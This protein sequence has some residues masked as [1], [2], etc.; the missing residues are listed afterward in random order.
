[1]QGSANLNLMIKAARK[2]GRSL[3]KDF[4]EV[5]NLQ[6][7]TKGPGDFVSQGRPRGRADHQGRTD[8][9]AADLWLAGR[10]N[11]RGRTGQDPTRRWIVDPLDGTTNFLHGLPHWAV[12][13]ALEHKGEIVSAW[14]TTR[15]R[16]RCSGRKGRGRLAE[17]QPP[18]RVSG[19]RAMIE[20]IFATGVPFG[21]R[22]PARHLQDLARLMPVCAGVR[23][24]GAAALDLAY[25]AAGRFDGYW[26]R[27]L[28]PGTFF[29][30]K[31]GACVGVVGGLD[32]SLALYGAVEAVHLGAELYLLAGLRPDRQ[33][34]E[35][36]LRAVRV[37]WATPAQLRLLA[38][39]GGPALPALA[40]VVTGG[41]ALDAP[42][43]VA[44]AVMA[45]GARITPFYG[46]AEASFIAWGAGA[47]YPG[48]TLRLLDPAGNP[49]SEGRVALQSPYLFEDYAGP[50]R[51]GAQWQ[52]GWL[53]LDEFARWQ[54]D[55]LDLLG[56]AGRMVTIADRNVWP[57]EIELFL[58]S[59][60][61]I[62][63]AAVLP[64]PD[65]RRGHLLV[66]VAQGDMAAGEAALR[67][68]RRRFGP[69]AAPRRI[70]WRADWPE[71]PSGKTDL[72]AL[73]AD[74]P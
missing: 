55:A 19:R 17:R 45:P 53:V 35:L 33:R 28:K 68:L 29:D 31:P 67:A 8:G 69:L 43:R 12:S 14:S 47:P 24:W 48:V 73:E 70:H 59:Q 36:A 21:G 3:V 20:A 11:R 51:G 66:A 9:R 38:D 37:L 34:V 65:P 30:I 46:A 7:S 32:A 25:V 6:V 64:R 44:V 72:R 57:E 10:G 16:T 26:E 27:G 56:R 13:I 62:A 61:G 2:A 23:R 41:A 74:L 18:L 52:D 58:A 42:T 40:H 63:R 49:A 5:E 60:P 71:L 22:H 15:P 4:R 54:E 1:M 50:D 39:A